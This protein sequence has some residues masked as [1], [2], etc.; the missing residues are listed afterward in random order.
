MSRFYEALK[1]ASRSPEKPNKESVEG[2]REV[3]KAAGVSP[4]NTQLSVVEEE[5]A[6]TPRPELEI[7]GL[8]LEL[9]QSEP[10]KIANATANGSAAHA[11]PES[12]D[13]AVQPPVAGY[14]PAPQMPVA[15]L[16]SRSTPRPEAPIPAPTQPERGTR[17]GAAPGSSQRHGDVESP[18]DATQPATGP[19]VPGK[20][21]ISFDPNARLIT[22][23]VDA[24]VVEHYRRLRTKILQQH[25]VKPFKSLLVASPS[26]QEG[27][28][29]TVLNLGLS[30]AMLPDFKVLVVDGDLRKGTIGKFLG[31]DKQPGLNDLMEG[32]VQLSDVILRCPDLP[33]H[34][35]VRGNS[36]VPPAELLNS[37]NVAGLFRRMTEEFDLVLVDSPPVN[38]ITDAQLLAGYSDAVLLIARAFSTT[39]KELEQAARELSTFR[40]IGTVLNGGTRAQLYRGYSG[41]Y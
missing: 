20:A 37:P 35:V 39:S 4:P 23:A 31:A 29:L 17:A 19:A 1:E 15:E 30:F 36:K 18:K 21:Q 5:K 12:L 8:T 33:I 22:Q 13:H 11:L 9:P 14:A 2:S 38:L 6:G 26:P 25:A 40:I 10:A 24:A 3:F 16:L 28:T 7:P 41:Y 27:K 34:F 32:T